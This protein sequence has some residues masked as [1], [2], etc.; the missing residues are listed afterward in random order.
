MVLIGSV[1][2]GSK[3]ASSVDYKCSKALGLPA[4]KKSQPGAITDAV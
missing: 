2:F 3:A 4:T 1:R